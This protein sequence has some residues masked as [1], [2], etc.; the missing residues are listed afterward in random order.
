MRVIEHHPCAMAYVFTLC[1]R[2]CVEQPL[3]TFGNGTKRKKERVKKKQQP[4]NHQ[5][6]ILWPEKEEG[7]K[8]R[9][10][11]LLIFPIFSKTFCPVLTVGCNQ[12]GC[13]MSGNLLGPIKEIWK[14]ENSR[15][16]DMFYQNTHTHRGGDATGG[17]KPPPI[18]SLRPPQVS[19]PF[20]ST[21]P[22]RIILCCCEF[23]MLKNDGEGLWWISHT[24]F[25]EVLKGWEA[26]LKEKKKRKKI[27]NEIMK[28]NDG[29][30]T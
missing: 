20:K 12:S 15:C 3:G 27:W 6:F 5:K 29:A 18:T 16:W 28:W 10:K 11:R 4:Q 14:R 30:W 19:I 8:K 7:E 22:Y 23:S 9:I 24:W 1:W 25:C 13:G 2:Q 21:P 17:Q 26:S